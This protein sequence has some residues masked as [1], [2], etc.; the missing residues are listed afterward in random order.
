VEREITLQ[1]EPTN[2]ASTHWGQ[3]AFMFEPPLDAKR[4]DTLTCTFWLRRQKRNHRL[5]E[6][7]CRFVL[8]GKGAGRKPLIKEEFSQYYYVD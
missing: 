5:L 4:G 7:E 1:T 2:G 3:Q 6:M 8:Q